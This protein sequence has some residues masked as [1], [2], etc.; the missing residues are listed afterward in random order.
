[1]LLRP[2]THVNAAMRYARS[3]VDGQIACAKWTRNACERQLYD[4]ER[5]PGKTY[6]FYFDRD[7]AERVC[8]IVEGFPHVAGIWAAQGQKLIL[9]PWQCFILCC[10]FGWKQTANG[11]RRF[12]TVYIECPRKNAK[13]TLTAAVGIILTACDRE[14]GAHV[15]SA[16]AT[17]EQARII[18]ADYA[19][20]MVRRDGKFREAFGVEVYAHAITQEST[21]S[22]FQAISAEDSNLD[23]LNL[24]GALID[25]LHAHRTRGVW[26]VL[27][28]ATG[29]R[30]QPLIWAITTA[31][32]NRAGICFEQRD[33]LTKLLAS[34][35]QDES[36]FGIIYTT[37]NAEA[38]QEE[39]TW[40]E[41]NPNYDVSVNPAQLKAEAKQAAQMPSALN[42]FL[43]KHLDIWVNAEESWLPAESW[44]RAALP[45]MSLD[46]FAG[47][48][49]VIGLDLATRSDVAAL[50]AL[51]PPS[52]TR[53]YWALFGR[54]FLPADVVETAANA[55]YS[56]WAREGRLITTPG[57]VTDFAVILEELKR[58]AE[59]FTVQELALD[60]N[61]ALPLT[62][63]MDSAGLRM[64]KVQVRQ[65]FDSFSPPMKEF[66]ALV[67]S[68]KLKH[69]GDPVMAWMISNTLAQ[70]DH[71]DYIRPVKERNENK[72]DGVVAALMAMNRALVVGKPE[73]VYAHRGLVLL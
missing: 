18:F 47:E 9:E 50:V 60:P 31:G 4:L 68:G 59:R 58:F 51:F 14:H 24:S 37:D 21:G 16:A 1:M 40:R 32:V 20:P 66:E 38:W 17:R 23:G 69:D 36:Y 45:S 25:E 5:W 30:S 43:T 52:G 27:N 48:P 15:V 34:V 63:A 56:G 44:R 12:R 71:R 11:M 49:C 64:P 7:E 41:A 3:V 73:S 10:V 35:V 26:D 72:I 6:E 61:G 46:D 13:S 19:Q 57:N 2:H 67:I 22:R 39:S 8:R 28:T 33:Y 53:D 54:F 70:R 42:A 55:S 65:N 62:N 29:A